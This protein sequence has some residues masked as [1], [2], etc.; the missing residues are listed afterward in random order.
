MRLIDADALLKQWDEVSDIWREAF[1]EIIMHAPTIEP[2]VDEDYLISLIQEAVYDGEACAR[3]MPGELNGG[4][5]IA[6]RLLS[7]NVKSISKEAQDGR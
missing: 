3:L 6:A 4:R 2:T 1:N 5:V 7:G